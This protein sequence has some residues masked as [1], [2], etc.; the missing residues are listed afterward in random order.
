MDGAYN[1][2]YSRSSLRSLA[3]DM[4]ILQLWPCSYQALSKGAVCLEA[5]K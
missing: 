2:M 1:L 5:L 4:A 3:N